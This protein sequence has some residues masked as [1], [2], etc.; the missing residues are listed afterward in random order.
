MRP[1]CHESFISDNEVRDDLTNV[2]DDCGGNI[3][4]PTKQKKLI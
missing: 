4:K 2:C 1:K 3:I